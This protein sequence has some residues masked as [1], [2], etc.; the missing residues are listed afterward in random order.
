[1]NIFIIVVTTNYVTV[2][3]SI[4]PLSSH[5]LEHK[6]FLKAVVIITLVMLLTLSKYR[7]IIHAS[8]YLGR[9]IYFKVT[10]ITEK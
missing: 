2:Q 1:M 10:G 3:V 6:S 7:Q 5:L 9:C 8:Q 4:V